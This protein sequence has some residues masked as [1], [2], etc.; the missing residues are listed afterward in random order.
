LKEQLDEAGCQI[1]VNQNCHLCG[2][3][4]RTLSRYYNGT[5]LLK[6][7]KADHTAVV[8][9]RPSSHPI[10]MDRSREGQYR[11]LTKYHEQIFEP[12]KRLHGSEIPGTGVAT[13][14]EKLL[15]TCWNYLGGIR[16]RARYNVLPDSSLR[17][18]GCTRIRA[19]VLM[20]CSRS[21]RRSLRQ[22]TMNA[23]TLTCIKANTPFIKIRGN[24]GL[25]EERQALSR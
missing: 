24:A 1:E 6:C 20:I 5:K 22:A 2:A 12:F 13:L 4:S 11:H 16:S 19:Q 23:G 9:I 8:Q 14:Y 7:Q 3:T 10:G 21:H 25:F 18:N 17:L 15:G